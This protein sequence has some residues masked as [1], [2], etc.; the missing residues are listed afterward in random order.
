MALGLVGAGLFVPAS[1]W[2][3]L[4]LS[5]V[6]FASGFFVVPLNAWLQDQAQED[7]RGRVISALN[8]MTATTGFLAS[9]LGVLLKMIGLNAS[10]QMLVLVPGLLLVSYLLS[11]LVRTEARP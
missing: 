10:Q 9:S 11:R 6:G 4:S 7:H 5:T 2:W 8:L 1:L 3:N